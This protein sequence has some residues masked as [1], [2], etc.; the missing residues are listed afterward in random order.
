MRTI[1]FKSFGFLLGLCLFVLILALPTFAPFSDIAA[2]L[3]RTQTTSLQPIELAA[4]IQSVFALLLLMVIWWV[5]EAI[6]LPITALMPAIVLPFLHVVGMA[7]KTPYEFTI[8]N[9]LLSYAN[10]VI[11]LFLGGFLIAAAMQ[12]WGLDRRLTLWILTRGKLANSTRSILFGM[13]SVSAFLSMWISNTATTAMMLPLGVG[14]LRLLN[15]KPGDSRYG[16]ALMLGLAW[17]ASIGGVGTIIGTPPNGIA[18]GILNSTF[19]NDPAFHRITFLDW[20]K[21]GVPY[22]VLMIPLAW[23][24]LIT[25]NPPEIKSLPGGK[26]RLLKERAQLGP[27]SRGEKLTIVAFLIAV[28]LWITNPFWDSLL[29]SALAARISWIDEYSIGLLVGALC[30][31]LPVKFHQGEFLLDWQ[32]TK[33]VDWGTLLLFGGGIALSDAMFKTGLAAWIAT[34]FVSVLGTPSTFVMMIAVVF[35]VDFLTEVTSNTAV[36][37]MIVPIVISIALSTGENPIT[38]AV[39]TA[40]AASMA[41]MLPVATPPNAL[42]Y[43]TGYVKLKDMIRNGFMLDILGWILTIGILY[44][45][46]GQM[47]GILKF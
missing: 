12:K 17:A 45:V 9:V 39:A 6:P 37:G 16:T 2:T 28:I 26:D 32:D 18:L 41:F 40:V 22:V 11:Y 21:F 15:L 47:F 36:T 46:A 34:S 8:K 1:T 19:A 42:V 43:G 5:S 33:F 4:S 10:P 24:I 31:L 29:P 30:F 38:L 35:L 14:I 3:L 7:G 27:L 23:F 13:M 44:F 25:R 20:M